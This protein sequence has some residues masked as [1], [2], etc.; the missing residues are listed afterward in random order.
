MHVNAPIIVIIIIIKVLLE[1]MILTIRNTPILSNGCKIHL[2]NR[3]LEEDVYTDQQMEFYGKEN[4]VYKFKKS[5]YKFRKFHS[6]GILMIL[7][8]HLKC[9]YIYFK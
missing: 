3:N 7:L 5:I 6:N 4:I 8:C 9:V 1:M 2:L